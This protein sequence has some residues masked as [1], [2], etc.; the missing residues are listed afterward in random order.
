MEVT[1]M[2]SLKMSRRRQWVRLSQRLLILP[3]P[4]KR[5]WRR[6]K[7]SW[8]WKPL[9]AAP[10]S[11]PQPPWPSPPLST[12]C[13]ASLGYPLSHLPPSGLC[14]LFTFLGWDRSCGISFVV[15]N[16]SIIL[17]L[18]NFILIIHVLHI[19]WQ[20]WS[21]IHTFDD[22]RAICSALRLVIDKQFLHKSPCDAA[23][24]QNS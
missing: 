14:L 17:A 10:P 18:M 20:N 15:H 4:L 21:G 8:F 16:K 7:K 19:I 3:L 23:G 24:C 5:C 2:H 12:Y 13:I 6:R 11:H 9:I 1:W 22:K